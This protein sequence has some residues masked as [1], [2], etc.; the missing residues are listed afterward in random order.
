MDIKK[1]E[2]LLEKDNLEDQE[3]FD[4]F[5]VKDKK[6]AVELWKKNLASIKFE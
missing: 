2:K 4:L 5:K 6:E 3:L 1:L